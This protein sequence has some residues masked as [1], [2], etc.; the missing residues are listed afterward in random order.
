MCE[1]LTLLAAGEAAGMAG[2]TAA[3]AGGFGAVAAET[4]VAGGI[5]GTTAAMAGGFA[6]ETATTSMF[7]GMTGMQMLEMGGKVGGAIFE[8]LGKQDQA[9]YESDIAR[10]N[11]LTAQYAAEDAR[12]RGDQE[13]SRVSRNA[14]S[15]AGS[16]RASFA[17]RGLDVSDGTPG[18]II[19]QTNFFGKVDAD[20]ARYNGKVEA[21]QKTVQGQNYKMQ[22]A[23]ANDRAVGSLAGSMLSG[24][25][26]VSDKWNT[27]SKKAA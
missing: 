22:Q 6:A 2:T 15:L 18:D 19:E 12:R 23:S 17:A 13:A 14:S 4:A 10:N 16:Q 26:A 9:K 8:G 21:W 25:S 1:P 7:S 27:Y 5:A 20:T 11:A 24:A 3:M